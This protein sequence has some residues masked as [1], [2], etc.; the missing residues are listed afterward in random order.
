V[1]VG[2]IRVQ[3]RIE[4]YNLLNSATVLAENTTYGA[5]FRLPT[6]ILPARLF[7][8]GVQLDF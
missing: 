1:N 8:V 3:P 5:Q 2:R 4:I 7:K 6:S